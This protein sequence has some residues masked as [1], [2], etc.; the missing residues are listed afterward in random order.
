MGGGGGGGA[1]KSPSSNCG[2]LGN[3]PILREG[4]AYC[5]ET[6]K[7]CLVGKGCALRLFLFIVLLGEGLGRLRGVRAPCWRRMDTLS[8]FRDGKEKTEIGNADTTN[9]YEKE[10]A[11]LT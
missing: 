3:K 6:I 11:L 7:Y 5:F 2:G 4:C 9:T 10:M 8:T 1:K